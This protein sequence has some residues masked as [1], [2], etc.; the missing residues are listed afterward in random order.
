[1]GN[2]KSVNRKAFESCARLKSAVKKLTAEKIHGLKV[3][4]GKKSAVKKLTA[5]KNLRLKS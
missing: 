3:N 1:M 2:K 5:E 4:H